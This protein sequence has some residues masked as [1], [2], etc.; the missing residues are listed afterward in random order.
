M[1]FTAF[2]QQFIL[3]SNLN[4]LVYTIFCHLHRLKVYCPFTALWLRMKQSFAGTTLRKVSLD[5]ICRRYTAYVFKL[6][7]RSLIASILFN[8][9]VD[10]FCLYLL[11]KIHIF[12]Y[13]WN[14]K[15]YHTSSTI[16]LLSLP[17]EVLV[18]LLVGLAASVNCSKGIFFYVAWKFLVS[19]TASEF[20]C[21][22]LC[23]S[24]VRIF[25]SFDCL[26]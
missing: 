25:F 13:L 16:I 9:A 14:G 6:F 5:G 20:T 8:I 18:G 7:S 15:K 4:S 26:F 1:V 22:C 23:T 2:V 11:Y 24:F 19:L 12:I 3:S 10:L 17:R 21:N